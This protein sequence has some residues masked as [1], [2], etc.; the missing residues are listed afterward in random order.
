MPQDM[1]IAVRDVFDCAKA[2]FPDLHAVILSPPAK[3]VSPGLPD[4]AAQKYLSP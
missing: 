4:I 2:I 1:T 3:R